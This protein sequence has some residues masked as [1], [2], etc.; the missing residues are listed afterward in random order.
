MLDCIRRA[1]PL[2]VMRTAPKN[3]GNP[4][5][6]N[7]SQLAMYLFGLLGLLQKPSLP[8]EDRPTGSDSFYLT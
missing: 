4:I 5:I 3:E 8:L 6:G 7:M 1:G 2:D